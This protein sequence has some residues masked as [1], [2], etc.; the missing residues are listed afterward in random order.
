[1]Q[2]TEALAQ[3][4]G[5]RSFRTGQEQIVRAILD[6]RDVLA[7]MPTGAG[8]SI[9]FQ[10]PGLMLP[11]ITLVIS[12][13]IS[14][15]KDQVAALCQAGIPGAYP[16]SSLTEAQYHKALMLASQGRYKIIYVA[17][18][19]LMTERFLRFTRSVSI[20]QVAVD[21]AHC[22]SQWG[23]DFRPGYL[24][25]PKFI[26]TLPVRPVVSAFTATATG[27]VREDVA[28]LLGLRDPFRIVTGFDRPN[29]SFEV[30]SGGDKP[31]QLVRLV[32][33]RRGLSGIVY[34]GT[35]K[36]VEEVHAGL[37]AAGFPATR[38]HA[39][40]SDEERRANQDDFLFDRKP[41]MVATNAFGMGID[42][43]DVRFVIHYNMP[44]DLEG[45]YQEAG[46][47]GRDGEPAD[48]VLLFSEQDVRLREFLIEHSSDDN[49]DVLDPEVRAALRARDHERLRIMVGYCRTKTCLRAY[50][51]RY[52]GEKAD[53]P[54]CGNCGNCRRSGDLVDITD[55][56]VEIIRCVKRFGGRFGRTTILALLRGTQNK[57]VTKYELD[58]DRAGCLSHRP[59]GQL[60]EEVDWLCQLGVLEQTQGQYPL[61]RLGEVSAEGLVVKMPS[62][63]SEPSIRVKRRR[64]ESGWDRAI[65]AEKETPKPVRRRVAYEDDASV[66]AESGA[67]LPRSQQSALF[68]RL[69]AVRLRL[70]QAQGVPA[71]VIF[72][73]AALRS[74]AEQ[75]PISEH[76]FL[77]VNGVGPEKCKRYGTEFIREIRAFL[78][79]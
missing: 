41:V 73:D 53:S 1:M 43:S 54:N 31:A 7:V 45:Y 38:Y 12:P 52:F 36:T 48:C 19:R 39:G 26:E 8:K 42:K 22:V 17:P 28:A 18:E 59:E 79:L 23:Q 60:R 21:E 40:L 57:S 49:A 16:N 64:G 77:Q 61:L 56:S 34:C 35:R 46:R 50:I 78:D 9:C 68:E 75:A 30:L 67:Q 62:F 71:F 15:M 6:G 29:L 20:S 13:L 27:R 37:E 72:S 2:P 66:D 74:M 10:L 69:R 33:E 14:L 32:R 65:R 24:D 4:Y 44:G 5:Y 76:E 51:L 11:G 58:Y 25:I 3:Y 70:A 63:R 47:A 55:D